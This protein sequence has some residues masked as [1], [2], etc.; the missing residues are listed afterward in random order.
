MEFD[1]K[2][3]QIT[4]GKQNFVGKTSKILKEEYEVVKQLG[5]GG[6]GSVYEVRN[7]KTGELRACKHLSKANIKNIKKFEREIEIMVKT[8]HPSIIKLYE[9]FESPRSYYLIMEECR[10][11]ELFDDIIEHMERKKMYSEERAS[12]IM[13]QVMSAISYCHNI[14]ICHRDIKPEN[15]LFLK[16]K[17]TNE[18]NP[19]KIIDFGLSQVISTEHKLT[20]RVGTAYYVA[21]EILHGKYNEK[22]DVWSAGVILFILISG[23]PPFNGPNDNAIYKAIDKGDYSF[24]DKWKTVSPECIDLIKKMMCP[25]K[26]RFSAAQVLAHPWFNGIK[27]KECRDLKL[28]SSLFS[29]YYSFSKFK[30]MALVYIASRL[31]DKDLE[32]LRK[33]FSLFDSD[34]DG[35]IS[36]EEFKKGLMEMNC[37]SFSTEQKQE[38]FKAIDNDFN[39]RIDYTEFLSALMNKQLY[40]SRERCYEVFCTLDSDGSGKISKEEIIK[41]LKV[42]NKQMH[43]LEEFIQT[44][45]TNKD[46]EID[47]NEF[48]NAMAGQIEDNCQYIGKEVKED[49]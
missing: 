31:N 33:I 3:S 9:V 11:G 45:D 40:L 1:L 49:K 4:F 35:Q 23:N 5:K 16:E 36:L 28:D 17:N 34:K 47:Y 14:G 20:S 48:L 13:M 2:T 26:D 12:A 43:H 21:P 18:R 39:G 30:R 7:K 19:V 41:A 27:S 32:D 42:S 46:G 22:C 6:Y 25:E 15:I 8:D 44:A 24:D 38:L 29:E 10:G 37:G